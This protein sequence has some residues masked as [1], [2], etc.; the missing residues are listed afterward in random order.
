MNP[1]TAIL[2]AL[3][4]TM[5]PAY[6]QDNAARLRVFAA[7]PNWSG[8][9]ET[10]LSAASDNLSGFGAEAGTPPAEVIAKNFQ[11]SAKPPY[12]P[13]WEQQHR[14]AA[15]NSAP[16]STVNVPK[17]CGNVAFPA[18]LEVPA[19]FQILVTPEET[20]FL[21][22]FGDARYVYTDGRK[23]PKKQDLWPT[24]K[25]DSIGHWEGATLVIATIETKPGAMLPLPG[26]AQLSEEAHFTERVRLVDPNIMQD[27]LTIDDPLRFSHPWQVSIQWKRVRDQD[28]M[29]PYDCA[30]NDRNP[31]VDGKVTI[32]PPK[33]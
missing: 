13:E 18:V 26:A 29:L 1:R 9:W 31:V 28:R 25:G 21:D 4:L 7:L 5:A 33:P 8:L 17:L 30:E 16:S 3:V 14:T 22:E 27:D 24:A 11:L 23:H 10:K 20:V 19:M 12:K 2:F 32:A 15:G 6:A